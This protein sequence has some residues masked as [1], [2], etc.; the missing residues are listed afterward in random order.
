MIRAE[1]Q[2]GVWLD[3]RRAVFFEASRLLV[4]SDLHWGYAES[5]RVRGNL[6]PDWGD[7]EIARNL[8]TLIADYRPAEMLWL[9]DSLHTLAGRTEAERFLT[10]AQAQEYL[11]ACMDAMN[12]S[13]RADMVE[14]MQH[15]FRCPAAERARAFVQVINNSCQ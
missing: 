9:G 12:L 13:S 5:H 3:A 2:P 4:V 11:F 6:L 15:V 8:R 10:D 14:A 1:L 7:A